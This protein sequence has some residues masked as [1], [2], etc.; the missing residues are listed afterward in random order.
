MK[1]SERCQGSPEWRSQSSKQ[2]SSS[3]ES[4]FH[5]MLSFS[6]HLCILWACD[7]ALQQLRSQAE[8]GRKERGNHWNFWQYHRAKEIQWKLQVTKAVGIWE[9]RSLRK[10]RW[11]EAGRYF[12]FYL[13]LNWWFLPCSVQEANKPSRINKKREWYLKSDSI[14]HLDWQ[15]KVSVPFWI[16]EREM[17]NSWSNV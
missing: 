13:Q 14:Y 10:D 12:I 6:L 15:Q 1:T 3:C 17:W 2:K 7:A 16:K 9:T 8:G 11:W 4:R 5:M